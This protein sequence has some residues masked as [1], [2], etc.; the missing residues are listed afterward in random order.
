MSMSYTDCYSLIILFKDKMIVSIFNRVEIIVYPYI[1]EHGRIGVP[2]GELTFSKMV[3]QS[4]V[5]LQ[6][7][8][9][10]GLEQNEEIN[11]IFIVC[12]LYE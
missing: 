4:S 9:S 6:V 2:T 12:Y 8:G 3:W 5:Y 11:I 1:W 7:S 10:E